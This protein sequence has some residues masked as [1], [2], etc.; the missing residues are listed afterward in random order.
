MYQLSDI[1]RPGGVPDNFASTPEGI[2]ISKAIAHNTAIK[3]QKKVYGSVIPFVPLKH[4]P[5]PLSLH[6]T[7]K[8]NPV[9]YFTLPN[10]LL[11]N[12]VLRSFGALA[13]QTHWHTASAR[14]GRK[15]SHFFAL[16]MPS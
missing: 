13:Q 8:H 12:F 6:S 15:L 5:P 3:E 11:N 2:R 7:R 4:S 1:P 10:G 14:L 9:H 16:W